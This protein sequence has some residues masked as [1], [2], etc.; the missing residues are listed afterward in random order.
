MAKLS[1]HLPLPLLAATLAVSF[2]ASAASLFNPATLDF[3]GAALT[4]SKLLK[5]TLKNSTAFN[6]TLT[7]INLSGT[8][9]ADFKQ[10]NNCPRPLL[11]GKSCVFSVTFKPSTLTA[12]SANLIVRT[13][14]P[15]LPT[16]AL[17]LKG[18]LY[19]TRLNDTGI[20]K[21]S[22]YT[23]NGMSC[24][25]AGFPR[26]DAEYGRDKTLNNNADGRAGFNFTKLDANGRVLPASATAW[27]CVRDNVTGLVWEKKP[28]GD[29]K[30]G[31]Q[32]L[33]DADDEYSWYST[34]ASN[35]GGSTGYRE[36][37]TDA[38]Y[39]R[40]GGRPETWCNTEAYVRRVNAQG[41]CGAKDWRLPTRQE[42]LGLVDMSVPPPGPTI[43]RRYFPD[44]V[45]WKYWSSSS[46]AYLSGGSVHVNSSVCVNFWDGELGSA[47]RS[48][49]L[50]V[51]LVRG[52]Q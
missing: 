16:I 29:G 6:I 38:C 11:A 30:D 1:N 36:G 3:G 13:N 47:F 8:N 17:P 7:S 12:R 28:N 33:H 51:R 19:P 41:W 22:N 39:G 20:T 15:G 10:T 24:P 25:A 26:Q 5:A 4:E 37:S 44:T 45:T 52:G 27:N 40:D 46:L 18:N 21:C 43:D 23:Q 49:A 42:L 34:D 31:N 2:P 32:G 35:N 48:D 50:A 14:Y 9:A